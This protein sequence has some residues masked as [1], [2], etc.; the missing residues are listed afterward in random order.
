ML[1]FHRLVSGKDTDHPNLC[2]DGYFEGTQ[3]MATIHM[4]ANV[5]VKCTFCSRWS[6]PLKRSEAQCGFR[7]TVTVS[8]CSHGNLPC[9]THLH[10]MKF[11]QA[12]VSKTSTWLRCNAH[13]LRVTHLASKILRWLLDY[14]RT[15]VTLVHSYFTHTG[16]QRDC[17]QTLSPRIA[18]NLTPQSYS[19]GQP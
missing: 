5:A 15:C 18:S 10:T 4:G 7:T 8:R 17:T 14:W 12:I 6:Q 1:Q 2:P 19:P 11:T 16:L 9:L 3:S 13:S